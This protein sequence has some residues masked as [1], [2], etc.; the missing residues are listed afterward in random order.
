VLSVSSSDCNAAIGNV[1]YEF[2]VATDQ[3]FTRLVAAGIVDE[4]SGQTTFTPN[5]DLAYDIQHFWRVRASDGDTTSAWA[6]TQTFRGQSSPTPSPSP[7]PGPAP[8]GPCVS[9]SPQAIVECERAKYGHMDAGQLLQFE[10]AVARSLNANGISGGPFGILR[11]TGGSSCGG[12]SCDIIC[13]GQGTSQRQYDI[14]N[15][16]DG[17]QGA[18]WGG[19]NTYP[20][21]RVDVC[22]IQ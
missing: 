9:G 5:G 13:A 17:A 22:E 8:G 4:M 6:S 11:K 18:T 19:P 20:N 12:Y 3:A 21:I 7:S 10:R 16:S 15:D 14:L 2:Q 1:A